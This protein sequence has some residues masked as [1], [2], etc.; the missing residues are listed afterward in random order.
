VG[1]P[2][3]ALCLDVA[4]QRFDITLRH[5]TRIAASVIHVCVDN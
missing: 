1:T 4:W 5:R 2:R 3:A